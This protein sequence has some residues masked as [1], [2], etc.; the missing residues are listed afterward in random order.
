MPAWRVISGLGLLLLL[1]GS[2][3]IGLCSL[4]QVDEVGDVLG[5]LKRRLRRSTPSP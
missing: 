4:M 3:Y 5:G 1:G 2:V